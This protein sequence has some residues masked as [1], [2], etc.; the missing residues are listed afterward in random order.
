MAEIRSHLDHYAPASL[1]GVTAVKDGWICMSF[2]QAGHVVRLRLTV[3]EV[4]HLVGFVGP[5][6][7]QMSSPCESCL[8]RL[9]NKGRA[10]EELRSGGDLCQMVCGGNAIPVTL[11][12]E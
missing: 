3:D 6:G 10:T 7:S 4:R 9:L 5:L 2:N 1:R 8:L 12:G 11:L